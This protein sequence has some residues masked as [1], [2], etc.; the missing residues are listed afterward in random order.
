MSE[1][2]KSYLEEMETAFEETE[3]QIQLDF[4]NKNFKSELDLL[5]NNNVEIKKYISHIATGTNIKDKQENLSAISLV[6]KRHMKFMKF[7][8]EIIDWNMIR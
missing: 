7:Y 8:Y 2:Y 3:K 4:D 6:Y 1:E 5:L